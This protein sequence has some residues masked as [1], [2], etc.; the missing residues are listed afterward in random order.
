MNASISTR[1]DLPRCTTQHWLSLS[2]TEVHPEVECNLFLS[3]HTGLGS[4]TA[5]IEK[6]SKK[7][8]YF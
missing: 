3:S 4:S 7:L 6:V 2:L 1:L 8:G 5:Y